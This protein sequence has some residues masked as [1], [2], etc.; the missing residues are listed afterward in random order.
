MMENQLILKLGAERPLV[1][2][3]IELRKHET[4]PQSIRRAAIRARLMASAPQNYFAAIETSLGWMGLAWNQRGLASLML[5]RG[6]ASAVLRELKHE[7]PDAVLSK[8]VPREMT[9]ELNEY[10]EGRRRE[11]DL[12]LDWSRIK[13]FQRTVLSTILKIPYGETRTYSWVAQK[14]GKP[15]APRAVARALATNPIPIIL[16][17]HRIIGSDGNLRGYGGGLPLKKKLLEMEGAPL[18]PNVH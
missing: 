1:R 7:F 10:A 8:D 17:C 4:I 14:I 16:P 2:E 3:L 9:R 18:S 5:P 12:P 11:F 6:N 13:P 15:K